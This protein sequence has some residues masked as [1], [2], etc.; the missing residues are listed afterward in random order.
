MSILL[1]TIFTDTNMYMKVKVMLFTLY[2]TYCIDY[3]FQ[4]YGKCGEKGCTSFF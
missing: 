2:F 3:N 4:N 1:L